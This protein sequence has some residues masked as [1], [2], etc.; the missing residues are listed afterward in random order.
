MFLAVNPKWLVCAKKCSLA[1]FSSDE[2]SI[3]ILRNPGYLKD[4]LW[5]HDKWRIDAWFLTVQNHRSLTGC[6]LLWWL[7]WTALLSS[8][9][10]IAQVETSRH[11]CKAASV[12][13]AITVLLQAV[14]GMPPSVISC[15][16]Q[17][18]ERSGIIYTS[19][20]WRR[21]KGTLGSGSFVSGSSSNVSVSLEHYWVSTD[22]VLLG[23]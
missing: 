18:Q 15:G 5:G 4:P 8:C 19:V 22:I 2:V 17:I 11:Q 10:Q 21:P 13:V 16:L 20:G 14:I 23:D 12:P 9:S 3:V 1:S 6:T 7:F